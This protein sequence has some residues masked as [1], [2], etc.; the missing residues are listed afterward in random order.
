V[1]AFHKEANEKQTTI[2]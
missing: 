1:P 2:R